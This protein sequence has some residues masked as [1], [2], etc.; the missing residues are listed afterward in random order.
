MLTINTYYAIII[1]IPTILG[2]TWGCLLKISDFG[3]V[4]GERSFEA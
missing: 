1:P 4:A 2:N 3:I